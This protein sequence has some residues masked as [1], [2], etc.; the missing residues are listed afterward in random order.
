MVMCFSAFHRVLRRILALR[1]HPGHLRVLHRL[2]GARDSRKVLGGHRK[3]LR[4]KRSTDRRRRDVAVVAAGLRKLPPRLKL[5]QHQTHA[6]TNILKNKKTFF[7]A[8]SNRH[9]FVA[10]CTR[11]MIFTYFYGKNRLMFSY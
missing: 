10:L 1:R 3:V 8:T 11:D 7:S 5:G 9:L 4:R 2:R 6:V